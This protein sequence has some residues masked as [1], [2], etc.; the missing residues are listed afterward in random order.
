MVTGQSAVL[1]SRLWL[2]FGNSHKRLLKMIKWTIIF[3]GCTFHGLTT[4]MFE[5]PSHKG[6]S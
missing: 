2:V 6:L 3:N 4:S 1:Y 5:P